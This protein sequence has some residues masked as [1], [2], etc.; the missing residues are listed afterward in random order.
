[1]NA[2]TNF[3]STE[4]ISISPSLA[5]EMLQANTANRPLDNRRADR[6]ALMI[7]R[8]EWMMNGD[9]I[10]F[11]VTNVLLDGQHRLTAIWK[12]GVTVQSLVVRG[13]P[14]ESFRTIDVG[15]RARTA[16]DVLAIKGEKNYT[17]L[18]S[19]AS[20]LYKFLVSGNPLNGSPDNQ[21]TAKQI[22]SLID[23]NPNIRNSVD[24]IARMKWVLRHVT[25]SIGG[26]C[27]YVFSNKDANAAASFFEKLESGVGLDAGS[28]I[29]HLRERLTDNIGGKEAIK[30][31]YKTA[32]MFKAFRLHLDD[33]SIKNLRVRTSG[34]A[35]E[36]DLFTL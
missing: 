20:L 24:S 27:H 31:H 10:R 6:M 32:L 15:G 8:G 1:M 2:R 7:K 23:A 4:I 25:G 34:D 36:K 11:S 19:S 3:I 14:D 22:E 5:A 12:S 13:L 9:A 29:L 35:P 26:F 18:A 30:K 21:P 17:H 16:S 28:P 33:A